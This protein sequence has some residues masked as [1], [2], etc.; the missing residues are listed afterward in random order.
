MNHGIP[1]IMGDNIKEV[2]NNKFLRESM[3]RKVIKT[4][5]I[6]EKVKNLRNSID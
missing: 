3:E 2:I 5:E 1:S 4:F 6:Q